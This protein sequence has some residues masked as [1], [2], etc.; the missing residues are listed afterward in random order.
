[1]NSH[2]SIVMQLKEVI[3]SCLV[4]CLGLILT[5]HFALFWI[6]DGGVLIYENSK[7]ILSIET[8]M[9]IAILCFGIERL[10]SF[11]DRKRSPEAAADQRSS[12][13]KIRTKRVLF[14][15]VLTTDGKS[16]EPTKTGVGITEAI[17]ALS[18]DSNAANLDN[19]PFEL[20]GSS[21]DNRRS[22]V[23]TTDSEAEASQIVEKLF[24]S[25]MIR[26]RQ[27]LTQLE[28]G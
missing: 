22:L 19:Y 25:E 13:R 27:V 6:Y 18:V 7:V 5:I 11:T 16:T 8:V 4:I 2:K 28:G 1:M 17:T 24:E 26:I 3:A 21:E 12:A 20:S 23:S 10:I 14:P 15:P 9:S